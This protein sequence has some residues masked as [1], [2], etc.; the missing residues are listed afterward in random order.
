MQKMAAI[1]KLRVSMAFKGK[2]AIVWEK[3]RRMC[4]IKRGYS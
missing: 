1:A 3:F 4:E 2:N